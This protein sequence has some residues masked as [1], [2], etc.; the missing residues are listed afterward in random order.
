MPGPEGEPGSGS[1]GG[2]EAGAEFRHVILTRFNLATPGRE[3]DLRNR[4]GWLARRF[5]IFERHCLPA[6]A[7]QAGVDTARDFTWI[8]F[9]DKD[10]PQAFK[11][12]VERCRAVQPF[13]PYYT[14]LFPAEGWPNAVREVLGDHVAPW[15]L[16]T[17]LDN[18]DGLARDYVARLHAAV[19]G[20]PRV[21]GA[22][23]F[24]HGFVLGEGRLY[25]H[26][27]PSN[28][29]ASWLEPFD[30]GARTANSIPHMDL[31]QHGTVTQVGGP[32]A[33][34]QVIH[35]ENVSNKIRGRR[36]DPK[37]ALER[38][39]AEVLGPL[40]PAGAA[41]IAIENLVL[42]PLRDLRDRALALRRA[43]VR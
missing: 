20:A 16:T 34:L 3:S 21:R 30:A 1:G 26:T 18:D 40:A 24:T 38:F 12:R 27:H 6:V 36:I 13:H 39:P 17:R 5:E 22:F 4:P 37:A 31:A 10:T 25:A 2:L 23:N 15:L 28:A 33:W 7:A 42:T 8:I 43:R 32:G 19:R 9:F 41:G 14:G 35:G 29:F 11:D